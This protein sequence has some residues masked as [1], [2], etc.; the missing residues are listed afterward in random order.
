ME[1]IKIGDTVTHINSG[2]VGSMKE[3]EVL[4]FYE[5]SD[6]VKLLILDLCCI[7]V[8]K[9]CIISYDNKKLKKV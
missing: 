8:H 5:G 4:S 9:D 6:F 2:Q 1:D 7:A 3:C